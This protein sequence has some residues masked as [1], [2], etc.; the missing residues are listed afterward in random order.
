MRIQRPKKKILYLK[1]LIW[2]EQ[3]MMLCIHGCRQLRDWYA[4]IGGRRLSSA[5]SCRLG[6]MVA[7]VAT[8]YSSPFTDANELGPLA[9]AFSQFS[10]PVLKSLHDTTIRMRHELYAHRDQRSSGATTDGDPLVAHRINVHIDSSGK[11]EMR[12]S[13]NRW[14]AEGVRQALTLFEFQHARIHIETVK[15]QAELL[16]WSE[17]A[18]NK[19]PGKYLLGETYP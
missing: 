8:L 15:M 7:G 16:K 12:S 6:V 13:F 2:A 1:R 14:S 10:D 5:E 11:V 4:K 19:P 9:P 18:G 3:S 17:K